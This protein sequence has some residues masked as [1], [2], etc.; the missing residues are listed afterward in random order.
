MPA[1]LLHIDTAVSE[2]PA[3][4]D[5]VV[6]GAGITG[7]CAAYWLARAGQRVVLLEKGRVGAEQSSRNWGWCRQQN[8]DAR[9]LPLSTRS[10]ELWEEITADTGMDLGF[11]R[12]GLLYLSEDESEIEGWAKW[13][14]F[15]RGEGV[16]T[17]MLGSAEA[18]ERAGAT[19]KGWKGGVWSP[20][21]GIADPSRAAPLIAQGVVRH[22]GVVLQSCA[23]RGIETS[24]GAVSGVVT[25]R[26][27]I[28]TRNAI[29]AGGAWAG[30]FLHQLGIEFPQAAVRSSILSV[31]PGAEGL[32]PAL[33][34][35]AVSVTRRGD[36]GH[37]LAISGRANL[38]PTPGALRGARHFLPMFAKRWR[39]LA[40]GGLQAWRAGFETRRIWR[41]DRETPMERMRVLDPRPS[42]RLLNETLS[43]AHRLLPEL[44]PL[45]VQAQ[46]A[47]FI[48]STPDGVPVID[49][50]IGLPG[51]VLAAGLSGH[52]FGIGPGV[53]HLTADLV[54]GREPITGTAQYRLARFG[55]GQ[56]GQ[57][58]DF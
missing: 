48:D 57:V 41:L 35:A 49:A 51:L 55:K 2:F 23:A 8:R 15:A 6:I 19:G 32:P 5:S 56:W 36:G 13:G 12:C 17:R 53:G 14:R 39:S 3:E 52:G 21:D 47:G 34:T 22:G 46:W 54:L 10:L 43:R 37:T 25:E 42:A 45:P 44:K 26:G 58:A 18:A 1:P 27:T 38:D 9:E 29:I 50:D 11:R 16:D 31:A 7:T 24:G 30:S 28:R 4:A 40:P 33:H 20:S